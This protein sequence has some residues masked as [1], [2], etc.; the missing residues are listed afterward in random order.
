[1][2]KKRVKQTIDEQVENVFSDDYLKKV[3]IRTVTTA[4]NVWRHCNPNTFA[5]PQALEIGGAGGITKRL[6]PGWLIS[7]VRQSIGV[8]LV[9]DA[10]QLPFAEG[11]F[12]LIYAIDV[13]HHIENLKDMFDEIH[14]VLKPGGIFFIREPYWGP[15]AQIVWRMFHPEDFS[16]NRL[17]KGNLDQDPMAG[18]QALAQALIKKKSRVPSNLFH[19]ELMLHRIGEMTGLAFLLSGGATFRTKFPRNLLIKLDNWELNHR[20]WLKVFGF[21]TA[22]YFVKVK[23]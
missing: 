18:N 15:F 22:F 2:I 11:Q 7:D 8:D 9:V 12:D 16:V 17:F 3:S 1:M 14:R 21:S 19:E 4:E 10:K 23:K 13:I 20:I 6:R 5:E